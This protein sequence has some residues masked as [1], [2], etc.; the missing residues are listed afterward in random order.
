MT[1][2]HVWVNNRVCNMWA[3]NKLSSYKTYVYNVSKFLIME[4]SQQKGRSLMLLI[5]YDMIILPRTTFTLPRTTF[6]LRKYKNIADSLNISK[7]NHHLS[8]YSTT[9]VQYVNLALA[10]FWFW[11][12]L[13]QLLYH[14]IHMI[15]TWYW[16]SSLAMG[17]LCRPIVIQYHWY[18]IEIG[19]HM[20]KWSS[21]K[22]LSLSEFSGD[23]KSSQGPCP[24]RVCTFLHRQ[25]RSWRQIILKFQ[26]FSGALPQKYI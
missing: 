8:M 23:I 9:V 12:R 2:C 15:L 19:R 22:I 24:L 11:L 13:Y 21:S 6:T 20:A 14:F 18:W 7:S 16:A 1:Y 17:V 5:L 3:Q 4:A 10:T 26:K 25:I